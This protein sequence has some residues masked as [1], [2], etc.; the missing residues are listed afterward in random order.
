MPAFDPDDEED[1]AFGQEVHVQ[2][3]FENNYMDIFQ[4][5]EYRL[6][7]LWIEVENKFTIN[8]QYILLWR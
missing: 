4:V 5:F 2:E 1:E 8:L 7:N 6:M 3:H